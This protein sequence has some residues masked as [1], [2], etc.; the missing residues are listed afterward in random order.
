M[1][2]EVRFSVRG[3]RTEIE[4]LIQRIRLAVQNG[5]SATEIA[6]HFARS[7]TPS[8]VWLAYNAAKILEA[9]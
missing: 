2:V 4:S 5:L 9:K 1:T 3:E 7:E 6:E 8:Q